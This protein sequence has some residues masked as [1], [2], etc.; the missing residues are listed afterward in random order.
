MTLRAN[1]AGKLLASSKESH[2]ETVFHKQ[3]ARKCLSKSTVRTAL[4]R[5]DH[6]L[7]PTFLAGWGAQIKYF[8]L[9]AATYGM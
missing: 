9:S 1:E 7:E 6:Y 8:F 3:L 5:V 4:G 2:F